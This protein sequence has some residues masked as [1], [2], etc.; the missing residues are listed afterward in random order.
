VA[1]GE[2]H[3]QGDDAVEFQMA[4]LVDD[5]HAAAAEFAE[6]LVTRQA[7]GC[8]SG[9]RAA[10]S[11]QGVAE[12]RGRFPCRQGLCERCD[13]PWRERRSPGRQQ[14]FRVR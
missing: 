12:R 2:D 7:L 13:A 3:L 9:R 4:G 8:G 10:V 11:L 5:A 14:R 6:D 1:A